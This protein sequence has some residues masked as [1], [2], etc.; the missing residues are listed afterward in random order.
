LVAVKDSKVKTLSISVTVVEVEA[1]QA[2]LVLLGPE[3]MVA[4]AAT[5]PSKAAQPV[6]A[7]VGVVLKAE[8][9]G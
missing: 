7:W 2:R 6:I 3:V 8:I 5:L 9:L 4:M 1:E